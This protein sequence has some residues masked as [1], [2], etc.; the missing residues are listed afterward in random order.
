MKSRTF[1][2]NH[3]RFFIVVAR[4]S[5]YCGSTVTWF[6]VSRVETC[7]RV[8][9]EMHRVPVTVVRSRI[10]ACT[11]DIHGLFKFVDGAQFSSDCM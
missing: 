9:S 2:I 1:I 6:I 10:T 11:V 8:E 7:R 3:C 5:W 4:V